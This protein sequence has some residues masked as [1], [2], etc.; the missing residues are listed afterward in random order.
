[1]IKVAYYKK[2]LLKE[3]QKKIVEWMPE[4]KINSNDSKNQC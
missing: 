4:N 1:M 2:T 3:Q